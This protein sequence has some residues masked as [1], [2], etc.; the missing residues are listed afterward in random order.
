MTKT[1]EEQLYEIMV[2]DREEDAAMERAMGPLAWSEYCT[3]VEAELELTYFLI[4][5][6][7]L[8]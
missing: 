1:V 7:R 6:G 3:T 5:G 8:N 4:A 2:E